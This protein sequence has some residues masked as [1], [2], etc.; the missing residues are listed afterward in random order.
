METLCLAI[1]VAAFASTPSDIPKRL[2][3]WSPI[4]TVLRASTASLAFEPRADPT[5][6][7][8]DVEMNHIHEGDRSN[9]EASYREEPRWD[10]APRT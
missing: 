2:E 8:G 5:S 3:T 10:I 9:E 1:V 4:V 7:N 6:L